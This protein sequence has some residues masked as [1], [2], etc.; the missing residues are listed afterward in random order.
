MSKKQIKDKVKKIFVEVFPELRNRKFV[1]KKNQSDFRDWDSFNH[2]KLISALEERFGVVFDMT[3]AME[4]DSPLKI[5]EMI[6]EKIP[7]DGANKKFNINPV[8]RNVSEA[9]TYW[10]ENASGKIFIKDLSTDSNYSYFTFNKLVNAGVRLLQKQGVGKGDLVLLNIKNSIEFLILYFASMRLGSVI[11]PI[12]P[13]VG[14]NELL[15]NI[16]FTKPKLSFLEKSYHNDAFKKYRFFRVEFEGKNT[17][18]K[19]L[20]TFSTDELITQLE[21]DSPAALYYSSGTTDKPKG[22]LFS[23]RGIMNVIVLMCQ[24]FNHHHGSIHLGIL[25]MA[26]TAVIH[27]SVLPVLYMGGTFVFSENFIKIRKDFWHIIEHYKVNYIQ[28]VPTVIIMIL[29]TRYLNYRRKKIPLKYIACGSAPLPE[30]IKKSFEEKFGI[31]LANLYGLSEAGHLMSD[32][33]FK[34]AW[35]PGSIGWPLESIDLKIF[36]DSGHEVVAGVV[37][38][39]VVKTPAFFTGYYKDRKRY[40]SSFKNGYFCTGDLGWHDDKGLFYYA[41]RKKDLIIKG[42]V[43]I[44]PNFIDEVL[45]KHPKVAEAA[46]VGKSDKFFGEII[47]SFVVLKPGQKMPKE[48][49]LDY[50]KKKLG[51]FKSPSEIEFVD[52]IPKTFSGKILRRNL[53]QNGVWKKK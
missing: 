45:I 50:C 43:N 31:R 38:E 33:P 6:M 36:D 51:E 44:S 25:P 46:S 12:P 53:G 4:A 5:I 29:N 21:D 32:Y 49:F 11:N 35:R 3:E 24:G 18:N 22:I 27:H 15:A 28:A 37:G 26:H 19:I 16:D 39:F 9:L 1:F 13:S 41:G 23:H 17:L 40:Q 47:K 52:A 34:G 48:D 7:R 8:F 2:M 42:G 14:E 20:E 30:A 10:S